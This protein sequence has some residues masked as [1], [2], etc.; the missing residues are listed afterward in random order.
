IDLGHDGGTMA[1]LSAGLLPYRRIGG[2]IEILLVHPG[3][4]FWAKKDLGAWSIVKG[5]AAPAEDLLAC[6][7]REFA[8]ETGCTAER[9]CRPLPLAGEGGARCA[10]VGG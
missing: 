9:S 7:R 8:E 2:T 5:E 6:A 3:G 4:P 10:A 1:K